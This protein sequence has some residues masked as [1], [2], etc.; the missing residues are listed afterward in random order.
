MVRSDSSPSTTSQPCAGARRFRRAAECPRR[1]A[2]QAR[3][4]DARGRRRSSRSSSSCRAPRRPRSSRAA[5]RARRGARLASCPRMRPAKAVET[6]ASQPSGGT[7]G[8]SEISTS[9]PSRCSR[10]GVSH[11]IPAAHLGAPRPRQQRVAR[12]CPPR[13]FRRSRIGGRQAVRAMSSSAISSAASGRASLSIALDIS[14]SRCSSSS[15]ERITSGARPTSSSG[16]TT[17]PPPCFEVARVLR[18][19]IAGREEPGNE[20]RRLPRCGKLPDRAAGT[21]ERKIGGAERSAELLR[22]CEEAV[23]RSGSLAGAVRRSRAC[24]RGAAPLD[25]LR[26]RR[27]SPARS[28]AAR[29]ASRRTRAARAPSAADRR[30]RRA[31]A[32]RHAIGSAQESAGR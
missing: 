7:G 1:S 24:P 25:L 30:A 18:L 11:A 27:R 14:A 17:A 31:S 16:T 13:R 8:S 23:V 3:G 20:H 10:Y 26:R 12:S 4:R 19:V 15:S 9:I 21:R 22:E 29:R 28:A 6:Y 5:R 2:T 32:L